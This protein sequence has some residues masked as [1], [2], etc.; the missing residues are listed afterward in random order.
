MSMPVYEK[1][2]S[3]VEKSFISKTYD[4]LCCLKAL[5]AH[6]ANAC[7][8][9]LDRGFD[10]N[11]YYKYFLKSHEKFVIRAKKNR[12]IIYQG[13]TQNIMDV[14]DKYTGNYRMDFM[15]KHGKRLHVR[16]AISR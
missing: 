10:G 11:K 6:F 7:V 13:K 16:S 9:T 4:N 14:A 3:T 8:R 12:N 15:D 5:S 1:V 2:F